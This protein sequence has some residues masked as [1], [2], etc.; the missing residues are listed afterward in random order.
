MKD[1]IKQKGANLKPNRMAKDW[2]ESR[3]YVNFNGNKTT[4]RKL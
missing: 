3:N 4:L 2:L 1:R